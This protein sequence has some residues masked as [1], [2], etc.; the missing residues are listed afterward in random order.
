[1][2]SWLTNAWRVPELRHRVLFTGLILG[3]YRLGSWMPAPGVDSKTIEDY[4][5]TG[6]RGGTVLGLLNLFSGSALAR[7]SL[8]ALGIMP[9]VTA[10]IILQLM[11]VV[12]PK[13]EALQK[14]GEAGYAKIN[15]YTRYLTIALAA[16][17]ATGYAFLFKRQGVLQA[18]TGRL[19]L[20]VV[21]L[22]AGTALLMY[23]GELI[24]KRGVGN[25]ISL[26]IFASILSSMPAGV[27]AWING[28][29]MEKLF[30]PLI[31]LG[32]I[33]AVVFV[34]EGQRKIPIQYAKRMVGRRQT[35]GGS[36]YMPLRVNMAG[37]IPVIFA[38][39]VMA[40]PP[41]VA[42]FF[43]TTQGFINKHLQPGNMTYLLF[44]AGLIVIFTYFYTAV[45][46][47]PVDQ[48]DNLRKYGGYVPGIRPGP[49]TAQYLDRVLTR[50]TLPGS[51][52]LAIV[53]VAPSIF[54]RYFGFS[55]ANARAL[56]GTSVLIAVGVA[57]DTMRQMESQMM[58]RSYEGFLK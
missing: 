13:L 30:F 44:E 55:Q 48:A 50:L 7:F 47:N 4:F 51:I 14:E 56:G 38:A 5:S 2:F 22:T 16:A 53:A 12:V 18:N 49:P 20:I 25:G 33:V 34:Q 1:V 39:A 26:L 58:M 45:Q 52:Y 32:V 46:F 3:L 17:Q 54:I 15:Q 24:T 29:P 40:F 35:T 6:G 23:M 28:G 9:Y 19:V 11:T 43:P 42:Q 27:S 8:F 31:A 21:T 37:V 10:S 41:T 57:L 36:T